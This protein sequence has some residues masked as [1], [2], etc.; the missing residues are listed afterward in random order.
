MPHGPN[1]GCSLPSV[2]RS[3][4]AVKRAIAFVA[5]QDLF[6]AARAAFGVVTP[7][8]RPAP[9][10]KWV[11]EREGWVLAE[12]CFYTGVPAR[13]DDPRLHARW[14]AQL[15]RM[16]AEGV[17]VAARSLRR[18][19]RRARRDDGRE[20]EF[21][22]LKEKG[23]DDRIA[24]DVVGVVLRGRCDVVLVFSQDQ[25]FAELAQQVRVIAREQHRWVKV[26]SAYPVG[27]GTRITRSVDCT[28]CIHIDR[29]LFESCR[30]DHGR[31]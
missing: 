25:D 4:P 27:P 6:A 22:V 29:R 13:R 14:T 5:G 10:A 7:C 16:R 2:V 30:D 11:T 28:D 1:G 12:V 3:A 23:S 15:R 31:H 21:T 19:R 24:L 9:L 8:Y 18:R 17:V 26:A 20:V